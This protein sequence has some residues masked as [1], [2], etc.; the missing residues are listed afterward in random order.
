MDSPLIILAKFWSGLTLTLSLIYFARPSVLVTVKKLM[1]EDRGFAILYGM[2]SIILGLASIILWNE[3]DW[4]LAAAVSLFGWL[5]FLKGI[6]VLAYPEAAMRTKFETRM[7][8][9]RIA[10][11]VMCI[12]AATV[13]W[14]AIT[15]PAVQ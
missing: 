1:V 4:W 2:T 8:T 9:T 6:L 13:L 5:C 15:N 10:L 12:L 14:F 3:W 7:L 11:A